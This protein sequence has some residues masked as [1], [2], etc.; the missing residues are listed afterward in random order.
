VKSLFTFLYNFTPLSLA[1][2]SAQQSSLPAKMSSS[3]TIDAETFL[4]RVQLIVN[5]LKVKMN[6]NR[7]CDFVLPLCSAFL[8]F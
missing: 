7:F 3:V 5:G 2:I 8:S 6:E 4:K 1:S